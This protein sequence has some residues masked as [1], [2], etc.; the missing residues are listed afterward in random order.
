ML[1]VS[2]VLGTKMLMRTVTLKLYL[3]KSLNIN[4]AD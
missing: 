3:R 2:T 4:M 1:T